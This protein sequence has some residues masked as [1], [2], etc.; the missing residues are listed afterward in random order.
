ML[1]YVY[2]HCLFAQRHPFCAKNNKIITCLLSENPCT[3][4]CFCAMPYLF[5]IFFLTEKYQGI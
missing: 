2:R 3:F 5:Q 4:C 1:K